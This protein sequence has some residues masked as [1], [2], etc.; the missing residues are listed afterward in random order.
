M[1]VGENNNIQGKKT[2]VS[3]CGVG[4]CELKVAFLDFVLFC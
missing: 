1:L 4:G 3:P 2:R